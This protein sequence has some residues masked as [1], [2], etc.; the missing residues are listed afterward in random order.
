M[1]KSAISVKRRRE[2]LYH[3]QNGLCYY[4]QCEMLFMFKVPSHQARAPNLCTIEHLRD[5]FDP[6]RR[7]P[8]YGMEQRWVAACNQCNH[9]KNKE[10][11]RQQGIEELRRRAKNGLVRWEAK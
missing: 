1:P 7:E 11:E 2:K 8:N 10:R 3:Q 5:R 4:C 9:E 6:T